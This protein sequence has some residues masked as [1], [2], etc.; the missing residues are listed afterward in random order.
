MAKTPTPLHPPFAWSMAEIATMPN[1]L[2]SARG[3][4]DVQEAWTEIRRL[5][6]ELLQHARN[7]EWETVGEI[8]ARREELIHRFFEKRVAESEADIVREGILAVLESDKEVTA[9]MRQ[10][11]SN[12]AADLKKLQSGR[13]AKKAYKNIGTDI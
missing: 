10:A 6:R 12:A 7:R 9:L 11:R 5:A 2:D 1:D 3:G 8:R 13:A 4:R